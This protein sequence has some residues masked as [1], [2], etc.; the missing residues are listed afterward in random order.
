MRLVSALCSNLTVQDQVD[1]EVN[2]FLQFS[3]SLTQDVNDF[4]Y[5]LV[6]VFESVEREMELVRWAIDTEVKG[7][8]KSFSKKDFDVD[9]KF[10]Y[11]ISRRFS[12]NESNESLF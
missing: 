11:S 12:I 1:N 2:N 8:C 5:A 10:E 4:S 9:S 3:L 7:T 6:H